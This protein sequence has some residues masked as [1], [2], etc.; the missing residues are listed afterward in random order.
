MVNLPTG[1]KKKTI[2][3]SRFLEVSN[4]RPFSKDVNGFQISPLLQELNDLIL[5]LQTQKSKWYHLDIGCKYFK[6]MHKKNKNPSRSF[7]YAFKKSVTTWPGQ[8]NENFFYCCVCGNI[9]K[10]V[11]AKK[12][13]EF[14][15]TWS[16]FPVKVLLC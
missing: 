8:K 1:R 14:D 3:K 9:F 4:K 13:Q 10:I 12:M 16:F 11:S 5:C 2:T 7:I 6:I 15:F